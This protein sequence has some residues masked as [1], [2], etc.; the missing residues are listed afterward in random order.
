[1]RTSERS[2]A[3]SPVVLG[4]IA[5]G[6]VAHASWNLLLKRVGHTTY[7]LLWWTFI[8]GAVALAPLGITS[9]VSAKF[10]WHWVGLACVCGI[11]EVIYFSLLQNAY[12]SGDVSLVYPM[13]RGTGPT[14]SVI[15]AILILGERPSTVALLG[16]AVVVAGIAIISTAGIRGSGRARL[17]SV[18]YGLSVGFYIACF[19]LWD[20]WAV[21][22]LGLPPVGYYWMALVAQALFMIPLALRSRPVVASL[23]AHPWVISLI[24]VLAPMSYM[25]AL[26]AIQLSSVSLVAPAREVSVVLVALGGAL[27]FGEKHVVQRVIGSVVV[28]SGVALLAVG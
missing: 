10:E 20:G 11:F 5:L 12:R 17:I 26:T 19:T 15:G 18:I 2:S 16:V 25:L 21:G 22:T 6:A 1:M 28:V 4:L 7:D 8:V 3:I 27:F 14:L 23:R 9:L 13:A 24:G